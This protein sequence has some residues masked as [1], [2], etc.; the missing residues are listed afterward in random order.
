MKTKNSFLVKAPIFLHFIFFGNSFFAQGTLEFRPYTGYNITL[1]EFSKFSNNVLDIGIAID[2]SITKHWRL[3]LDFN[4]QS[5]DFVSPFDFSKIPKDDGG[6]VTYKILETSSGKWTANTLSF[7]SWYRLYY[8]KLSVDAYLK[9]GITILKTPE[10]TTVFENDGSNKDLFRLDKQNSTALG[11]TTGL[12]LNYDFSKRI[13]VYINPQYVYG[14][15]QVEYSKTDIDPAFVFNATSQEVEFNQATL[16]EQKS[17]TYEFNPSYLNV[18]MGIT[19][20]IGNSSSDEQP[21]GFGPPAGEL[22]R[23][24]VNRMKK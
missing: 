4:Q 8:K 12:R 22:H 2:Y 21:D 9:A 18:N 10:A 13:S 20:R 24:K 14:A 19:F 3:G 17:T 5:N 15:N 7:G 16:L 1:G 6:S 23:Q 11:I